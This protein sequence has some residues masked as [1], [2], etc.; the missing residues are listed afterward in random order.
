MEKS[1]IVLSSTFDQGEVFIIKYFD[2]QLY[3]VQERD[4]FC[5]SYA[6]YTYSS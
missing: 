4:F 5:I 3:S 1:Q 2:K 6:V